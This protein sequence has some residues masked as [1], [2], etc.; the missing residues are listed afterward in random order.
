MLLS[1]T[2][3]ERYLDFINI[4]PDILLRIPQIWWHPIWNSSESLSRVERPC[5]KNLK[6]DSV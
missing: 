2:A 4:Y 5:H 3:E 6:D 1:A